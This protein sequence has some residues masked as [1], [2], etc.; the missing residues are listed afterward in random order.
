MARAKKEP[1]KQAKPKATTG[2]QDK[3]K[4][5]A[6]KPSTKKD[7]KPLSPGKENGIVDNADTAD[8][9]EMTPSKK[10]RLNRWDSYAR[11]DRAIDKKLVPLYGEAVVAGSRNSAGEK[12]VEVV[13][14]EVRRL[15]THSSQKNLSTKFWVELVAAFGLNRNVSEV[16]Q[17]PDDDEDYSDELAAAMKA[18]HHENP[19]KRKTAPLCGWLEYAEDIT[20]CECYGII[21]SA[22]PQVTV[23]KAASNRVYMSVLVAFERLNLSCGTFAVFF[24][25]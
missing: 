16:L 5:G 25:Q 18:M 9:A 17:S 1:K 23:T 12:L 14:R 22:S 8:E 10:R 11:A 3:T 21:G 13:Q 4:N 7:M 19:A 24:L 6:P 15:K 20:Y 2:K